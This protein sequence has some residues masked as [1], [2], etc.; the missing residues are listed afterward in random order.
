MCTF[1]LQNAFKGFLHGLPSSSWFAL[2]NLLALQMKTAS[3]S[4][5]SYVQFASLYVHNGQSNKHTHN[6]W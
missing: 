3:I 6:F 1:P 4:E 5:S 2:L